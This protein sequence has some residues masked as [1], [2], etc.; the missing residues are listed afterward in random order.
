M[1]RP[2]PLPSVHSLIWTGA[3]PTRRPVA[4]INEIDIL[5]PRLAVRQRA[6]GLGQKCLA[7]HHFKHQPSGARAMRVP[8]HSGPVTPGRQHAVWPVE[9]MARTARPDCDGFAIGNAR[10]RRADRQI[11]EP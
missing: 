11:A 4:G 1:T 2:A 9:N 3:P 7:L 6:I 10:A 8:V 5:P